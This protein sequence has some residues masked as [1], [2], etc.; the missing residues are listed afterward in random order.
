MVT[1][2]ISIKHLDLILV[3]IVVIEKK[4]DLDLVVTLSEIDIIGFILDYHLW[5]IIIIGLEVLIDII[6]IFII[7]SKY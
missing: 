3:H 1:L 2:S 5:V 4:K 7:I 6:I